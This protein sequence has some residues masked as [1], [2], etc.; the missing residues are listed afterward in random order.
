MKK[1]SMLCKGILIIGTVT[2]LTACGSAKDSSVNHI[3]YDSNMVAETAAAA[4]AMSPGAGPGASNLSAGSKTAAAPLPQNRKLIRN[5]EI[6]L[7]TDDFDSLLTKLEGKITALGGYV[8]NSSVS[9]N[10]MN[11][12]NEPEPRYANITARIPQDQFD[13]FLNNIEGLANVTNQSSS[14]SDVTVQYT[15]LESRKKTL[16]VEQERIW[17]IL[18]KADT[19]EAVIALE[20]RLSEIRY[21]LESMESQLRLYDNQV[22]YSTVR[23]YIQEVTIF[24]PTK[25]VS[26]GER[27]STGFSENI[28]AVTNAVTTFLVW[29]LAGSPIWIPLLVIALIVFAVIRKTIRKKVSAVPQETPA[30]PTDT[31]DSD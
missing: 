24:T 27:I 13:G 22:D 26:L 9:G 8:E 23:L 17:A 29:L 2:I 18:E 10:S 20:Q 16:A 30:K 3:S 14:T 19:L 4:E 7:E 31:T 1:Q 11:Y 6:N 5:A 12:R 15:D 28:T 25:P 21:E